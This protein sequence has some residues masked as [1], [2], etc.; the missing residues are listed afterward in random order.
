[1]A[2]ELTELIRDI[3]VRLTVVT[4]G[5]QTAIELKENTEITVILIGGSCY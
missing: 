1:M 4:S 2:L 3:T 5:L